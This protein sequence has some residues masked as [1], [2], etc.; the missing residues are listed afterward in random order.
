MFKKARV[1]M[2]NDKKLNYA[3]SAGMNRSESLGAT[4]GVINRASKHDVAD[5][6]D[7][8]YVS[9][10]PEKTMHAGSGHFLEPVY[11]P[12]WVPLAF[13]PDPL[14]LRERFFR[15]REIFLD[16]LRSP[17][18]D[19]TA[20]ADHYLNVV[21]PAL[22]KNIMQSSEFKSCFTLLEFYFNKLHQ[23]LF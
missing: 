20:S 15:K 23:S 3:R 19:K 10:A 13:L 7:I 9:L 21:L 6:I 1:S 14:N 5:K 16:Q 12:W 4:T 22:S 11:E 8:S 17:D 2:P 18:G